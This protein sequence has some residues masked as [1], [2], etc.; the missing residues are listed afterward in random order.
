MGFEGQVTQCGGQG[1]EC[2]G[3]FYEDGFGFEDAEVL[4]LFRHW[5]RRVETGGQAT[6]GEDAVIGEVEFE[7]RF[8]MDG[9]NIAF[10]QAEA[11]ESKG[12]VA[13]GVA[14]LVPGAGFVLGLGV[15]VAAR[16]GKRLEQ[17]SSAAVTRSGI[18]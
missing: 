7:A 6:E 5:N 13:R 12:D 14:E 18:G 8:G 9:G 17:R 15:G 10:S 4:G 16:G 3:R 2:F 11:M 1:L